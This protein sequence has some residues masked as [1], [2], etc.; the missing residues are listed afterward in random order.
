M[1]FDSCHLFQAEDDKSLDCQTE[2]DLRVITEGVIQDGAGKF[3]RDWRSQ[4]YYEK[5]SLPNHD[6]RKT[7][8]FL[9][10]PKNEPGKILMLEKDAISAQVKTDRTIHLIP[11]EHRSNPWLGLPGHEMIEKTKEAGLDREKGTKVQVSVFSNS[12]YVIY[13]DPDFVFYAQKRA[14]ERL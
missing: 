1:K 4:D 3:R 14:G 12:A 7:E 8:F 6:E 9:P 10:N 11:K 5:T 2:N 13:R